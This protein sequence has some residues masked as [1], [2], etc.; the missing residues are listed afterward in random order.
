MSVSSGRRLIRAQVPGPG[1]ASASSSSGS[2]PP[3]R[4]F[5]EARIMA[6]ILVN[7]AVS[8]MSGSLPRWSPAPACDHSWPDPPPE[9]GSHAQH[10]TGNLAP[11]PGHVVSMRICAGSRRRAGL[12]GP[13]CHRRPAPARPRRPPARASPLAERKRAGHRPG[14]GASNGRAPAPAGASRR[15]SVCPVPDKS[16]R[17]GGSDLGGPDLSGKRSW[18][19]LSSKSAH[20]GFRESFLSVD[21]ARSLLAWGEASLGCLC[22]RACWCRLP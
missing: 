9:A 4:C 17:H 11:R 6:R 2:T 14:A 19:R 22:R 1:S 5:S 21:P 12:P 3:S 10:G 8:D 13:G 7:S 15:A 20:D 16:A 18:C